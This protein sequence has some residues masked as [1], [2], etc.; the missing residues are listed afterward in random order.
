M[1]MIFAVKTHRVV[2]SAIQCIDFFLFVRM[3][4]VIARLFEGIF[5]NS[6]FMA[7]LTRN[8]YAIC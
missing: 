4:H 5:S 7:R 6:A 1:S 2:F 8:V 3:N